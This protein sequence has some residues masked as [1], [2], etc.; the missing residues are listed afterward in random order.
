MKSDRGTTEFIIKALKE[1]NSKDRVEK[2]KTV[3]K[4]FLT[5]RQMGMCETYYRALPNLHLVGSNI[6]CEF[7][8]TGMEK[9]QFLRKLDDEDV[10]Q[11]QERKLIQIAD[12]DGHYV[13]TV[14]MNDKYKRRP[15]QLHQMSLIQFIKR[16]VSVGKVEEDKLDPPELICGD[17]ED[18]IINKDFII[19]RD[20]KKRHQLPKRIELT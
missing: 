6:G 13:E 15:P 7:V 5:H 2:I 12:R 20:S 10:A 11:V 19:C 4:A 16:Y 9:S 14:S 3:S 18:N 1:Q 17:S 8:Q